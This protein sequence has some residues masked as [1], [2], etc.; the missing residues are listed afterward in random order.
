LVGAGALRIFWECYTVK[1]RYDVWERR[2]VYKIVVLKPEGM[3]PFWR[4]RF[5]LE[6]DFELSPKGIGREDM[7]WI[8]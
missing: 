5:T 2:N 7:G 6:D 3:M 4:F 8:H 1:L